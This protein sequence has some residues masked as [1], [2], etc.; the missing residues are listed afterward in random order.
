MAES[1]SCGSIRLKV[2]Q[3]GLDDVKVVQILLNGYG[4]P[5]GQRHCK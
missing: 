4:A 2:V 3:V 5:L 1:G